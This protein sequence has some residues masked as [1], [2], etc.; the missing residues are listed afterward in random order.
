MNTMLL[1]EA[2]DY[3]QPIDSFVEKLTFG[4][5][6]VLIGVAAVFAVLFIIYIALVI[7][8]L[9]FQN[10]HTSDKIEQQYQ[11]PAPTITQASAADEEIVAVMAA[12]IAIAESEGTGA[13]FRV[14]SFRR[15]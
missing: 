10:I 12:A 7:F 14:V 4:G 9:C 2:M 11:A 15:V 8:K 13:K 6:I 3:S 5:L 1:T